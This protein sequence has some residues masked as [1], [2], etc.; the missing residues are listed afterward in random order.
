MDERKQYVNELYFRMSRERRHLLQRITFLEKQVTELGA[1]LT[2]YS[3]NQSTIPPLPISSQVR[4][5]MDEYSM[6]W[7]LFWCLEH[8]Q[9]FDELDNSFPYFTDSSCP[10]CRD[11]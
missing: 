8:R 11:S 2:C 3:T 1:R 4:E 9:W 10:I 7:E 6:P 5:W